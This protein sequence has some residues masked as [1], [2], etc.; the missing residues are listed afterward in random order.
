MNAG[1]LVRTAYTRGN[2][3]LI[4]ADFNATASIEITGAPKSAKRLYINGRKV[5][6]DVNKNGIWK[7]TVGYKEPGLRLPNLE[8]LDWKYIDAL[9]ELRAVMTT[10]RGRLQ[11]SRKLTTH[12]S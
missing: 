4:T 12:E 1:Y 10:V 7:T 11:T 5:K 3:L 6:H 8:G 2:K 9:L